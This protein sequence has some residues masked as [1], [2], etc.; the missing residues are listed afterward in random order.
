VDFASAIPIVVPRPLVHAVADGGL[1]WMAPPIAL[2][3]IG[4]E[5]RAARRKVS[6]IRA[7][8]VR[9]S[10]WSQTHK[11]CSPVS[12]EIT[13]MMGRRLLAEVPCPFRLFARRSGGSQGSR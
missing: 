4:I 3:R 7:T 5:A 1:A 10:A 6:A 13:L 11:R 8:Q 12:R 9:V 2:P